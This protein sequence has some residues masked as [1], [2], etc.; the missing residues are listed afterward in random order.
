MPPCLAESSMCARRRYCRKPK[1]ADT[2]RNKQKVK[3]NPSVAARMN[4]AADNTHAAI[5][6]TETR[7]M[8]IKDDRTSTPKAQNDS[9]GRNPITANVVRSIA[10]KGFVREKAKYLFHNGT[11]ILLSRYSAS[12]LTVF[13]ACSNHDDRFA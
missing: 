7:A 6:A 11:K 12:T 1:K 3:K 8:N 9:T 2:E 4:A 10:V 5:D 13:T